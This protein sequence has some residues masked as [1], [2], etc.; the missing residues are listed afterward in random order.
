MQVNKK[1]IHIHGFCEK[2]QRVR[3]IENEEKDPFYK[4]NNLNNNITKYLF[5]YSK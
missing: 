2:L 3:V 1:L 5:S 4:N